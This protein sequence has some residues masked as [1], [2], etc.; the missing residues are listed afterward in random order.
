MAPQFLLLGGFN[1]SHYNPLPPW[2]MGANEQLHRCF[3]WEEHYVGAKPHEHSFYVHVMTQALH[4]SLS[5]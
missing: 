4:N 1:R 3:R 5:N 2:Q